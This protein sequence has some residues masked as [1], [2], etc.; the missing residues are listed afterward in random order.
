MAKACQAC[1]THLVSPVVDFDVVAVDV[2]VLVLVVEHRGGT[3]VARVA[4][5]VVSDHQQYL[6]T[7]ENISW[8]HDF[9]FFFGTDLVHML[10]IVMT[11]IVKR[12]LI[13]SEL[14]QLF[15]LLHFDLFS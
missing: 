2:D 6:C 9:F 3:G 13:C 15:F 1:F 14:A 7:D 8:L 4:R 10:A 5:H 11:R 12:P